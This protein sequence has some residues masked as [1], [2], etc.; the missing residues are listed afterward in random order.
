MCTKKQSPSC[1]AAMSSPSAINRTA[2]MIWRLMNSISLSNGVI[3]LQCMGS[4]AASEGETGSESGTYDCIS[5][6]QSSSSTPLRPS[7]IVLLH[8]VVLPTVLAKHSSCCH[9]ITTSITS[10]LFSVLKITTEPMYSTVCFRET[11]L[12]SSCE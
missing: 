4:S 3:L 10:S 1:M 12:S 2:L 6:P 7:V 11:Y 8:I 9:L 5:R